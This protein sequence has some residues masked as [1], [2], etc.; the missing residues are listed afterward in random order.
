VARESAR[1]NVIN[2]GTLNTPLTAISFLQPS[3]QPRFR[4]SGGSIDRKVGPDARLIQYEEWARPTILGN[5]RGDRSVR[6]RGHLW[7]DG[8]TGRVLKTELL[9][10][11]GRFP[12]EIVTSFQF[13]RDLQ[14]GVPVEMRERYEV[15]DVVMTGVATY[16]QFRR[17]QVLTDERAR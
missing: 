2:I 9:I 1:Y 4:F 16:S 5:G 17:Y 14:I 6:A 13:N 7:I 8:S 3:Y 11:A 12:N 10:D 15:D